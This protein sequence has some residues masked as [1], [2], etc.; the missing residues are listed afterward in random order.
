MNQ[1]IECT[2]ETIVKN[3]PLRLHIPVEL[4]YPDVL[5]ALDA[6]KVKVAEMYELAQKIQADHQKQMADKVEAKS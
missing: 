6:L 3:C 2:L 5:E 4:T 1:R